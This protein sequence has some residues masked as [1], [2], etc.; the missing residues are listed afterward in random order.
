[1]E[2]C[3]GPGGDGV[4]VRYGTVPSRYSRAGLN[5]KVDSKIGIYGESRKSVIVNILIVF[6]FMTHNYCRAWNSD[7]ILWIRFRDRY[8]LLELIAFKVE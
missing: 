5:F 1:M 7:Q 4:P 3:M 2:Q 8:F 6:L